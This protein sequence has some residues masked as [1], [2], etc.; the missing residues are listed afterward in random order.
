[1]RVACIALSLIAIVVGA[2]GVRAQ[3][4][5]VPQ[6]ASGEATSGN[7]S[8]APFKWAGLLLVPTPT[9]KQPGLLSGC[10]A[11][12]IAP[13]VLLTAGHCIKDLETNPTGPWPGSDQRHVL[14]AVPE[15]SRHPVQDRLRRR[16]SAVDAAG[17]LHVNV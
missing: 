9:Q 4:V 5:I 2:A 14:A 12:F 17:Q 15:Q 11:Q 1:M 8:Q 7:P 16:Q 3:G 10:T 13:Q 6:V